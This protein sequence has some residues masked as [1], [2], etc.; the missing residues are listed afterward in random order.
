MKTIEFTKQELEELNVILYNVKYGKSNIKYNFNEAIQIRVLRA[1]GRPL[2]LSVDRTPENVAK[3]FMQEIQYDNG[4]VDRWHP[5]D[6]PQEWVELLARALK[7]FFDANPKVLEELEE[8]TIVKIAIGDDEEGNPWEELP[9]YDKI[10]EV[11][12][13]YFDHE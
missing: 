5:E 9:G 4:S 2:P 7:E 6:Y 3:R 8:E 10:D 12:N 11:L 13:D 1:L